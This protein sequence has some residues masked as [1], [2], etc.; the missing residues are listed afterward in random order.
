MKK[1]RPFPIYRGYNYSPPA[2]LVTQPPKP[3]ASKKLVVVIGAG[4]LLII[5]LAILGPL[6]RH[7]RQQANK[8]T[9]TQQKPAGF[10]K[11]QYSLSDSASLWVVVNKSRGL[12]PLDYTPANLITPNVP[13]RLSASQPEMHMRSDAA[14]ALE[15]M[16]AGAAAQGIKL[17]LSSGYRSYASQL[18]LHALYVKQ[19]G[20]AEANRE[21]A[22]AGYSEHQTGLAVDVAPANGTCVVE[23][24]FATAPEGKWVAANSYKYGFIVRYLQG[25]E[26]ITGYK[27]EPWHIRYVGIPLATEI[28]KSGQTM[29][30]FFG[31][32]AAPGN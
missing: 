15:Q 14:H 31:L 22:L 10:D 8:P 32:P 18:Q 4:V 13:L 12:S 5:S 19:Q 16:F 24:C 28:Y 21:S 6:I 3:K 2:D 20:E 30:G 9:T 27:Y 25:K 1:Q 17:R 23:D 7:H 11:Q 29:E 26:S